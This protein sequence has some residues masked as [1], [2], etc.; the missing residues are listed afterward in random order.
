MRPKDSSARRGA[1]AAETR[2]IASLSQFTPRSKLSPRLQRFRAVIRKQGPNPYVDV[3][4][5]VSRAFS[6]WQRDGRICVV[7]RLNRAE[8]RAT[9]VP[10]GRKG[11]RLYVNG[12]MRAAAGVAVGDTVTF[13]L[14]A[15]DPDEI[16]LPRDVAAESKR[17]GAAPAFA[18]L[19]PS[20]RRQLLR[21]IDDARTPEG[22]HRRIAKAIDHVIR[23]KAPPAHLDRRA[24]SG[25]A[26]S[27]ATSSS[28]ATSGTPAGGTISRLSSSERRR[29]FAIC[30]IAFARWSKPA[31]P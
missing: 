8:I 16:R 11:H 29:S 3:P 28:T 30:S 10:I 22:R 31:V 2:G 24:R 15:T 6:A 4:P 12:G 14:T 7:G 25:R 13:A 18:A 26:R 23:R 5:P 9:L 17:A 21:Y 19:S 27:A 1:R 20:H